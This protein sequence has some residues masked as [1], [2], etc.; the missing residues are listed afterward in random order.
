MRMQT[1]ALSKSSNTGEKITQLD[2]ARRKR[3][4]S[5]VGS[6]ESPSTMEVSRIN[7]EVESKPRISNRTFDTEK[8]ESIK[9]ALAKG[10][11]EIDYLRVADKFIE[12]E[13]YA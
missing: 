6:R 2:E 9:S 7:D 13:R 10:L 12:H 8:V 5:P 11:Y 1:M 3:A 4:K